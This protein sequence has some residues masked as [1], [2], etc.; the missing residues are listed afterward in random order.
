[1]L[2]PEDV[3]ALEAR[4]EGAAR[5]A[6]ATALEAVATVLAAGLPPAQGADLLR[7][8]AHDIEHGHA[9]PSVGASP[10]LALVIDEHTPGEPVAEPD[11]PKREPDEQFPVKALVEGTNGMLT[12]ADGGD[13][14]LGMIEWLDEFDDRIR[15][16][17]GFVPAVNEAAENG[18][19]LNEIETGR[20][21]ADRARELTAELAAREGDDEQRSTRGGGMRART[22]D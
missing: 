12:A 22:E 17:P 18:L 10:R 7:Q 11:E 20:I 1:M 21:V 5:V 9:S 13:L 16:L 14:G 3:R 19:V 15:S 2:D 8:L 4:M 6:M